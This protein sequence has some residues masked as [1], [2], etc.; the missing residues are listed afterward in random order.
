MTNLWGRIIFLECISK[1]PSKMQKL[2]QKHKSH[3]VNHIKSYCDHELEGMTLTIWC[4]TPFGDVQHLWKVSP[5]KCNTW[6]HVHDM[7]S[8]KCTWKNDLLWRGHYDISLLWL[9][10]MTW[11]NIIPRSINW[12]D[13]M[14]PLLTEWNIWFRCNYLMSS[15]KN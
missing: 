15:L 3:I 2:W 4:N 6:V 11:H 8:R 12:H 13:L 9:P 5:I 14:T 7:P 10:L 1:N